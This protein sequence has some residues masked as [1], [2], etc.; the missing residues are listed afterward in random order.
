M[1]TRVGSL[2][3][4]VMQSTIGDFLPTGNITI[5]QGK[6]LLFGST[7]IVGTDG[8]IPSSAISGGTVS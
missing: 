2:N 7:T 6:K 4:N 8:L 3:V 5:A 1:P